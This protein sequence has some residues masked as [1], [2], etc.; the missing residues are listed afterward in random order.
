[1]LCRKAMQI[2]GGRWLV[3]VLAF[4]DVQFWPEICVSVMKKSTWG[5]HNRRVYLIK[6][7]GKHRVSAVEFG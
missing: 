5:V 7:N 4:S 6:A 2:L 3:V 1:M